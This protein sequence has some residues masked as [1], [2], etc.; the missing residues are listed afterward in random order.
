M[1]RRPQD[2]CDDKVARRPCVLVGLGSTPVMKMVTDNV[3]HTHQGLWGL[4]CIRG[5]RTQRAKIDLPRQTLNVSP[6][7][8][9]ACS[10]QNR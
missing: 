3:P 6:F 9:L 10:V 8:R 1:W 4:T 7:P 2:F 5:L